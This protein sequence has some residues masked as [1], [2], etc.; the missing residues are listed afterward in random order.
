MFVPVDPKQGGTVLQGRGGRHA[1][2][3]PDFPVILT[4]GIVGSG[5]RF[6]PAGFFQPFWQNEQAV[7][8][9]EE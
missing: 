2:I 9:G 7:S 5:G 8:D 3:A 6:D 4:Y 1:R